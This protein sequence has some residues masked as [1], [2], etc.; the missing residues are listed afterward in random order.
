MINILYSLLTCRVSEV[1]LVGYYAKHRE[2]I[3][4][5]S[6][7]KDLLEKLLPSDVSL[8]PRF[9]CFICSEAPRTIFGAEIKALDCNNTYFPA[10]RDPE[11]ALN[12]LD[13]GIT[14]LLP[15]AA[16]ANGLRYLLDSDITERLLVPSSIEIAAAACLQLL[17]E[18]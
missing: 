1:Q 2:F 7:Q 6:K 9:A 4:V 10:G 18:V 16:A 13:A 3:L 14:H 17:R 8:H 15:S 11:Q 12:S 5:N